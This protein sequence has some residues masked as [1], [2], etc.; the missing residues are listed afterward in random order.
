MEEPILCT[1]KLITAQPNEGLLTYGSNPIDE[2]DAWVDYSRPD[3]TSTK[4]RVCISKNI[5][6][7]CCLKIIIIYRILPNILHSVSL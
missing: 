1:P 5:L 2:E 6:K 3:C 7:T 4:E